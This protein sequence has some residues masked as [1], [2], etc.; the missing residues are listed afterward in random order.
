MSC[1]L[2]KTETIPL[3]DDLIAPRVATNIFDRYRL[4]AVAV[5]Y[6]KGHINKKSSIRLLENAGL[7][8]KDS[9]PEN[10]AAIL[11]KAITTNISTSHQDMD[12]ALPALASLSTA[13]E[14]NYAE[15]LILAFLVNVQDDV[16][17]W[18]DF[19]FVIGPM[20]KKFMMVLLADVLSIDAY[21]TLLALGNNGRLIKSSVLKCGS[22]RVVPLPFQTFFEPADEIDIYMFQSK[23]AWSDF[24]SSKFELIDYD[25]KGIDFSHLGEVLQ[26]IE[27]C[28]SKANK[29]RTKGIHVL[30]YGPPGT[31]K[32]TLA[33]EFAHRLKLELYEVKKDRCCHFQSAGDLRLNAYRLGQQLGSAKEDCLMLFDELEDLLPAA[34]IRIGKE[35]KPHKGWICNTLESA[36]IPTIWTSNSISG[37]DPAILRRFTF[38]LEVPV[39]AKRQRRKLLNTALAGFSL[40]PEW[41]S[42]IADLESLTPA[43]SKQLGQLAYSIDAKAEKLEAVLDIWLANYLRAMRAPA[44]SPMKKRTFDCQL[45]NSNMDPVGLI[46]GLKKSREGRIC[47][48]GPPGTGK[49]AFARHIAEELDTEAM[50]KRGS[51]IR[52][53]WVGESEKN[54][55]NM[56]AEAGRNNA[57]LILDEA[58]SFLSGRSGRNNQWE[59]NEVSEF[60]VQLENF[61]GIFCATT[62][63]FED[64][65]SAF[66]RRFDLKIE[67]NYFTLEQ[68]LDMFKQTLRHA[69][70]R[71]YL[72]KS[73]RRG[74]AR[75]DQLSPGDFIT[76]Q[77]RMRFS[78]QKCDQENLLSAL[79][80]EADCK[81]LSQSRPIGFV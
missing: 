6:K 63:R 7:I 51:D 15:K 16:D 55:A 3:A 19:D 27:L 2:K 75:L 25:S 5:A 14:L 79:I 38:T 1:Q 18:T 71:A 56:F 44:L 4:R 65:D 13:L 64:L 21:Q 11:D 59:I 41:L 8:S 29:N 46:K 57:V 31:G 81:T 10:M 52:S 24:F 78:Q 32:T 20:G 43:M 77:R 34:G 30:L 9:T 74:L 35:N 22:S 36:A 12:I 60:L 39:P 37:I 61:E 72:G 67:L 49:T 68:R 42:H 23:T 45:M 73:T 40:S 70:Y 17:F 53:K 48:F 50:V 76:A 66:I 47:L 62:N 26:L 58:D 80:H 69:G 33:R 54:I 28:L